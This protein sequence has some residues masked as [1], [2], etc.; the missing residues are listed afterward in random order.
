MQLH[1]EGASTVQEDRS[2][3]EPLL[4]PVLPHYEVAFGVAH[5]SSDFEDFSLTYWS[6]VS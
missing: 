5:H 6:R 2:V 4:D 3:W 1:D